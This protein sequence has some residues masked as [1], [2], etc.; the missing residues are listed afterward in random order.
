[1]RW[2]SPPGNL[3]RHVDCSAKQPISAAD[4]CVGT[5]YSTSGMANRRNKAGSSRQPFLSPSPSHRLPFPLTCTHY[6]AHS[7]LY[8]SSQAQRTTTGNRRGRP[9]LRSSADGIF[10]GVGRLQGLARRWRGGEG[11]QASTKLRHTPVDYPFLRKV[12][13]QRADHRA[14]T[15]QPISV[16]A[17]GPGTPSIIIIDWDS[18]LSLLH[19]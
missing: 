8:P 7:T 12:V 1:M 14:R 13:W 17:I 10:L 5:R 11:A 2:G 18:C 9:S 16:P 19:V 6:H 15:L 4:V 3:E